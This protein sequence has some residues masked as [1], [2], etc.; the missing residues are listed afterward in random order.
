MSDILAVIER[1]LRD[2]HMSAR[3]ASIDAV[4][5]PDLIREMRRGRAPSVDRLRALCEVL[6]LEFYIGPKRP[7]DQDRPSWVDELK[8][9]IS[10]IGNLIRGIQR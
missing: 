3:R 5:T 9:D 1:A 2:K 4:G 8:S 6:D 10:S 7:D